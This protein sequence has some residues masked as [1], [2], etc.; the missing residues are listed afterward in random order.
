LATSVA[1]AQKKP[2]DHSVYDSWQ[3]IGTK[4]LSNDGLWAAYQVSVQEGDGNLYFQN[5]VTA[6]KIKVSR[7]A[8]GLSGGGVNGGG[9]TQGGNSLF[10]ADSKFA[11]FSI[12]PQFKDTRLAKIKKKKPD[13][14][15][16]DT[17]GIANLTTLNIVKIPRVKSFKFP[18][19]GTAIL[20]YNLEKAPDTAKRTRPT[21]SAAEQKMILILI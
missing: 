16:K 15:T 6:Q 5:G 17:L 3:S 14:M 11:A 12:K 9:F 4:Q 7:G 1:L 13:E 21:G 8:P 18:E 2:L 19:N 20:A 10:S